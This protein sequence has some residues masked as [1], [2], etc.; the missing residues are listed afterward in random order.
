MIGQPGPRASLSPVAMVSVSAGFPEAKY[1]PEPAI[2]PELPL[3]A[4]KLHW[5]LQTISGTAGQSFCCG[6]ALET[7]QSVWPLTVG[8]GS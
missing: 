8:C 4:T 3:K 7:R 2:L 6:C 1:W 5:P